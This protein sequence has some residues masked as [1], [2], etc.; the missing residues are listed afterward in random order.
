[1]SSASRKV[2]APC[3]REMSVAN[4]TISSQCE[5]RTP[6]YHSPGT[7]VGD[8]SSLMKTSPRVRLEGDV[9]GTSTV[10]PAL[11]DIG[12]VA[13]IDRRQRLPRAPSLFRPEPICRCLRH[14][15][16]EPVENGEPCEGYR[17]DGA[18]ERFG[19]AMNDAAEH[20]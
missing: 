8:K 1:M 14:R 4:R 3:P 13:E 19:A 7:C 16:R 6:R 9:E 10:W 18:I 2:S 20:S 17:V 15:P 5:Q 12:A 11:L